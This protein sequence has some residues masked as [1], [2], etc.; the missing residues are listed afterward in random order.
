MTSFTTVPSAK[1]TSISYAFSNLFFPG[2]VFL[3]VA[4][5]QT[6]NLWDE[7]TLRSH[8]LRHG[9][10]TK[11]RQ[12]WYYIIFGEHEIICPVCMVSYSKFSVDILLSCQN[13]DS[14]YC[15]P[16]LITMRYT[17]NLIELRILW[18][19]QAQL[20]SSFE[21]WKISNSVHMKSNW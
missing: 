7:E 9:L 12:S 19:P 2:A 4:P 15:F 6:R 16:T 10:T 13:I 1:V 18:N 8:V 21:C 17:I 5:T 14:F 11:D 3:L 20:A